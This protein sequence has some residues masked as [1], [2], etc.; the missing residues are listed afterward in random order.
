VNH[1]ISYV[2]V[3]HQIT[4]NTT[5]F[6]NKEI[7]DVFSYNLKKPRCSMTGINA[8]REKST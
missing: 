2:E 5:V 7:G 4:P 3:L 6:G 1:Q 8:Q